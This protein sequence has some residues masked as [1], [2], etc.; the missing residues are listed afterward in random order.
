[1]QMKRRQ[2]E[3]RIAI[4]RH[5]ERIATEK[6]TQPEV[7]QAAV[8]RYL[9]R[10]DSCT[11]WGSNLQPS[12]SEASGYP[13]RKAQK[14]LYL[15]GF[16]TLWQLLQTDSNN[17]KIMQEMR[18]AAAQNGKYRFGISVLLLLPHHMKRLCWTRWPAVL[19]MFGQSRI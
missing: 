2:V 13:C 8:F 14:T 5:V 6:A 19:S 9:V 1:M 11:R 17:L 4:Y 10:G 18:Y 7:T 3:E 15:Q 16:Y 12:A